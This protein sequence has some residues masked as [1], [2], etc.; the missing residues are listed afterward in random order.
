MVDGRLCDCAFLGV[1]LPGG[2]FMQMLW[3]DT[4]SAYC[5]IETSGWP[6]SL[7]SDRVYTNSVEIAAQC[8]VIC[9]A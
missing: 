8:S 6:H 4:A 7:H 3:L 9:H 1:R 2:P 5:L